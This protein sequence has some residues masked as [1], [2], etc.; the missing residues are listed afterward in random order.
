MR[1]LAAAA[2]A[3]CLA[4]CS[5]LPQREDSTASAA[6]PVSDPSA[7]AVASAAPPAPPDSGATSD[8]AAPPAATA[9]P[10][11]TTA[12]PSTVASATSQCPPD[13]DAAA[14]EGLPVVQVLFPQAGAAAVN[15]EVASTEAQEERGLMY[16][17]SMPQNHGMLFEMGLSEDYQFWMKDT[18]IPL[19]MIFADGQ[20]NIVGIVQNAAPLNDTPLGVGR[21]SAYILE[22]NGGWTSKNGVVTGQRMTI[23]SNTP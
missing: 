9:P 20:G 21:P 2:A 5:R 13:P 1:L 14:G 4:H 19:D 7:A 12:E 6:H 10:A 18:C 8:A 17:T 15:A 11:S 23:P 16:R 22:V 3:A